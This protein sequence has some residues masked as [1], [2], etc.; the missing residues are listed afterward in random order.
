MADAFNEVTFQMLR[1]MSDRTW[2]WI[3]ICYDNDGAQTDS[4]DRYTATILNW[5]T[6]PKTKLSFSNQTYLT[7]R[8]VLILKAGNNAF[9][10][11]CK[12]GREIETAFHTS[13]FR[14][15][16]LCFPALLYFRINEDVAEM[17]R[18]SNYREQRSEGFGVNAKWPHGFRVTHTYVVSGQRKW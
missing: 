14:F 1:G 10:P 2:R 13:I 12:K 18:Y 15:T 9:G 17:R 8:V 4:I 6:R 3:Y 7:V 5:V 11:P 16:L